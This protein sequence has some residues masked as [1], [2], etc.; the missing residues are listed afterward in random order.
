MQY[1]QSIE[2]VQGRNCGYSESRVV[3]R[4]GRYIDAR[5]ISKQ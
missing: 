2:S 3:D 5:F 1:V 4:A